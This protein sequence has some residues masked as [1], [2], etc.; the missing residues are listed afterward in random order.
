M[1]NFVVLALVG[2]AA[3]T[4]RPS[5]PTTPIRYS[6][7]DSEVVRNGDSLLVGKAAPPKADT[8]LGWHDDEGDHFV[9][10]PTSVTDVET[11]EYVV[12]GDPR[13]DAVQRVY[14]T[15]N[16]SSTAD[17]RL[18]QRQVCMAEGGYNDALARFMKGASLEELT[19]QLALR[20]RDEARGLVH[21]ALITLQQRYWKDR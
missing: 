4:A 1:R 12:P 9:Q 16:G 5:S 15:T 18:V 14:D 11:V 7:G 8:K 6:C 21:R 13:L 3:C 19:S 20:D 2:T 17:W 10:W